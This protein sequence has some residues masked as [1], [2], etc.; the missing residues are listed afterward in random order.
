MHPSP[1]CSRTQR[2]VLLLL[3]VFSSV[4]RL[5]FAQAAPTAPVSREE[6]NAVV[7]RVIEELLS[8]YVYKEA[9]ERIAAHLRGQLAAGTYDGLDQD[10]IFAKALTAELRK[11]GDDQ[12]LEVVARKPDP[13][14]APPPDP[15]ALRDELRFRNF[16][17]AR[18]ASLPGN[19]RYLEI[20]SFP[21][22]EMAGETAVAAMR[23]LA[24]GDAIIIDLRRNGGGTGEMVA[25][26]STYFFEQRT[27]LTRTFRRVEDQTTEDRTLPF[28][29]GPRIPTA[30]LFIL[31]SRATFSAAEAFAFGLQQ[32][33]RAT[34]V[35]EV[36]RG[37]AN[38]GRYR[39][40]T[41]RFRVFV[42][43]AHA[44]SAATGRTW[45]K[46][47]I[48]PDLKTAASSA[49]DAAH[50]EALSRLM[51]KATDS[52]RKRDLE[53]MAEVVRAKTE[54]SKHSRPDLPQLTGRYGPYS[55]TAEGQE[56]FYA[57]DAN[58]RWSLTRISRDTYVRDAF[59]Y[60]S[61]VTFRG[62]GANRDIVVEH[63]D[64][65]KEEFRREE[66]PPTK[67]HNG[68]R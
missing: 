50:Q 23:F 51:Q 4:P 6:K 48:E 68:T 5:L 18:I 40:A 44:T 64:G 63:S 46:V 53:W 54:A 57:R 14:S 41:E 15:N 36:T 61:R 59:A 31:T 20:N 21:P 2:A 13:P 25:L 26:L 55:I 66:V 27:P 34:I 3:V 43:N 37:G 16:D 62:S 49:L 11:A 30:D 47:G 17:F 10:E 35:G 9:A 42:P 65:R 67:V 38:A 52:I 58:P 19:V 45:D 33:K 39:P 7:E 1:C 22:P 28:V 56:L 8:G 32:I 60:M 24:G 29:P 12:H